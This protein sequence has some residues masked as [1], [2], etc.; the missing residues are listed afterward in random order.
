MSDRIAYEV[1]VWAEMERPRAFSVDE[2]LDA[3]E[4]I[5]DI[6]ETSAY[7]RANNGPTPVAV[8]P[9][10]ASRVRDGIAGEGFIEDGRARI[11]IDFNRLLLP[12]SACHELAHLLA[13]GD[14]HSQQWLEHFRMLIQERYGESAAQLLDF[15]AGRDWLLS[16]G[17][18]RDAN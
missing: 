10:E 3:E 8:S 13:Y 5:R 1:A 17:I 14:Y 16:E 7:Y 15:D 18:L 2:D 9:L 12:W 6:I 4:L 11:E